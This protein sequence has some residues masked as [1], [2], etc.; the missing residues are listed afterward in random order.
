MT[1]LD[2]N[3]RPVCWAIG[4]TSAPTGVTRLLSS[5]YDRGRTRYYDNA[6]LFRYEENAQ[7]IIDMLRQE[8]KFSFTETAAPVPLYVLTG[9]PDAPI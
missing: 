4:V 1:S 6:L 3:P 9:A 2:F 5:A 7:Y 8:N